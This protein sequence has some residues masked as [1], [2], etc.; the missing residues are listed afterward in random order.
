L[1][2]ASAA[3]A[4]C[5]AAAGDGGTFVAWG[6]TWR[7][8]GDQAR[9]AVSF[10]SAES[11]VVRFVCRPG[12]RRRSDKVSRERV[13]LSGGAA[14]LRYGVLYKVHFER[15]IWKPTTAGNSLDLVAGQVH[16][17]NEPHDAAVAHPVL[18]FRVKDGKALITTS[19]SIQDPLL[20]EST[21]NHVYQDKVRWNRWERY[22]VFATFH[23]S[24]G[25]LKIF[26][27][28]ERIVDISNVAMG[29]VDKRGPYWKFG[30]Y[31]AA[32]SSTVVVDFRKVT[33]DLVAQRSGSPVM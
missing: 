22:D 32:A 29:F 2:V 14:P 23:P 13:E 26:R 3:I 17:S 28:G 27:D 6:R 16:N 21:V 19:A 8:Q 12:Y 5:C 33:I 15:R 25:S 30:I 10:Q 24:K 11:D 9:S 4:G 20:T 31:R 18:A 1:C 7:L